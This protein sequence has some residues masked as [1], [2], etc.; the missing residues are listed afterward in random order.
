M[1]LQSKFLSQLDI[2]KERMIKLFQKRG[3]VIGNKLKHILEE[4]GKTSVDWLI[5]FKPLSITKEFSV[6]R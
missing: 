6:F 1:L 4:I 5:N 2:H 3:G